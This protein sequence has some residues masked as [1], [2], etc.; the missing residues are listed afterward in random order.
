MCFARDPHG[1]PGLGDGLSPGVIKTEPM[2]CSAVAA[3]TFTAICQSKCRC[4]LAPVPDAAP[5]LGWCPL[6]SLAQIMVPKLHIPGI[7]GAAGV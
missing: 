5:G 7:Q 3:P 1:T 4:P 6:L 2:F